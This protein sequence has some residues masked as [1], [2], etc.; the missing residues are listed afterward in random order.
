MDSSVDLYTILGVSPTASLEDI[1]VAYRSAA[2]RFHPD[3]N[4]HPGAVDQFRD[5][6]HAYEV[7]SDPL[8]RAQFDQQH[9]QIIAGEAP[10]F[11][12]RMT[13]SKRVLP[14]LSEAQVLY[15]LVELMPDRA[16]ITQ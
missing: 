6:A 15:L 14:V 13:P 12:L 8:A 16:R 5:I 2:H 10:Y 9:K 11:T 4:P 1:R 3:K 7:L